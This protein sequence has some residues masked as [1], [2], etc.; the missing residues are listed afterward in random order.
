[1]RK[2]GNCQTYC[3]SDI[4]TQRSQ[5][6]LSVDSTFCAQAD[7]GTM[8]AL[9]KTYEHNKSGMN[10]QVKRNVDT[11]FAHKRNRAR[12]RNSSAGAP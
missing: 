8:D 4:Q 9:Q 3:E 1:M 11:G 5:S 6:G 12:N 2:Y 7:K 10:P